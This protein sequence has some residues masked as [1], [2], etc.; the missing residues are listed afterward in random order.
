MNSEFNGQP[1]RVYKIRKPQKRQMEKILHW[2]GNCEK[3][4]LQI[5]A[6]IDKRPRVA[7]PFKGFDVDKQIKQIHKDNLKRDIER[8]LDNLLEKN[9]KWDWYYRNHVLDEILQQSPIFSR[10]NKHFSRSPELTAMFKKVDRLKK[11]YEK[12]FKELQGIVVEKQGLIITGS[13]VL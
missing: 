9:F 3:D 12:E 2:V 5:S 8:Y 4:Y 7:K 11:K 6:Q 1:F 13:M 10:K